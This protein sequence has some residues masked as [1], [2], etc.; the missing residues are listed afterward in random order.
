MDQPDFAKMIGAVFRLE[1]D[2]SLFLEPACDAL[3]K[4]NNACSLCSGDI[5][6]VV[7]TDIDLHTKEV[8][9]VIVISH[10]GLGWIVISEFKAYARAT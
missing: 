10:L 2:V 9:E 1:G 8:V 4:N 3:P 6:C 7:G 5:I